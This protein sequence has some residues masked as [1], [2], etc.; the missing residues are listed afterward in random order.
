MSDPQ[1]L[2]YTNQFVST[3]IL[4]K[5]QM[6]KE[7]EYYDRFKNYIDNGRADETEKYVDEDNYENSAVNL[8]KTLHTKWP[9]NGNK[10]QYPLFD[11]YVNDISVNRY[12]KEII[13]KVNIDNTNRDISSYQNPN[14]FSLP[15]NKT[16]TNVKKIVINDIIF[17]NINESISNINN[18]LAWQYASQNN[19]IALNI[20][21][22]IIP[23]PDPTRVISYS[24]LTNSAYGYNTSGGSNNIPNLDDYLVY[25]TDIT[26]GFYNVSTLISSIKLAT[27]EIL[28]GQNYESTSL[29]ILEQPYLAYPKRIGTPHLINTYI[30]PLSSVVRFVNR[31]E[32]IN[33]SAIQTFSPYDNNFIETDIFYTFSSQY[34]Q[35]VSG[36]TY[37]TQNYTLDTS[38]IY[39]LVPAISDITYQYYYNVNCIYTPNP[40][41]LVIT[42]L[43]N[44]VGNIDARLI[45]YTEFY[46]IQIYLQNGYSEDELSSISYYKYIDTITFSS[47]LNKIIYDVF[48][49]YVQV[50]INQEQVYLRF[51]L[52]LSTGNSNSKNY[53]RSGNT[54]RPSISSNLIFTDSINNFL[55]NYGNIPYVLNMTSK[56]KSNDLNTITGTITNPSKTENV[57]LSSTPNDGTLGITSTID[58]TGTIN[59]SSTTSTVSLNTET[60]LIYTPITLNTTSGIFTNFQFEQKEILVGRALLFRWIVDKINGTYSTY[61]I[62]TENE[63]KRSLLH[64]LA[65]PIP[66]QSLQLYT[67]SKNSGFHF[68]QANYQSYIIDR[69]TFILN[70]SNLNNTITATHPNLNLNLQYFSNNYYFINNSYIFLKISFDTNASS[71]NNNIINAIATSNLQYDQVYINSDLLNVNIGEDYTCVTKLNPNIT[72]YKKDQSSIFA[73]ILLSNIPGNIDTVV[74]NIINNN[75]FVINYSNVLDNISSIS[76]EVYDSNLKLLTVTNNFSFTLNIHEV[77][78]I[79]KETLIDTKT[80]NVVTTGHFI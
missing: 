50:P 16:F 75:S 15:F 79:L 64:L 7:T 4:S 73:K 18:N 36:N 28:H 51:A 35:T 43:T 26:S 69:N 38:F 66:N 53:N 46:D 58:T 61:E 80:N 72:I 31:M 55:K 76:I 63:K 70:Q 27:S 30:D 29:K 14:N 45:N 19:L 9:P 67:V 34:V 3:N 12:K 1:D 57:N 48:G 32:E 23:V 17:Q 71:E 8:N 37:T 22:T 41:P 5:E 65:W 10:N 40:F 49:N 33:I 52:H 21:N 42:N 20:D 11:S 74:S 56:N 59:E 54:I 68:V 39:I 47:T 24:S 6:T 44:N 13:T 25:Q 2:L 78:D 77:K 62:N 60:N